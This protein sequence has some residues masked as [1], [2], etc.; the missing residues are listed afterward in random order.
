LR[1]TNSF[2]FLLHLIFNGLDI[3]VV[4]M[5][6]I[7]PGIQ[8]CTFSRTG[9]S[10]FQQDAMRRIELAVLRLLRM[11]GHTDIGKVQRQPVLLQHAQYD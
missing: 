4:A 11:L 2:Q 6:K 9:R 5:D 7:Y 8:G 1:L 10:G 3:F